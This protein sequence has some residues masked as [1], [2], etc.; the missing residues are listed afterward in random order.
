MAFDFAA[1]DTENM[2]QH[3]RSGNDILYVNAVLILMGK[4]VKKKYKTN[5]MFYFAIK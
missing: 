2:P 4:G 3:Q 1:N 5:R